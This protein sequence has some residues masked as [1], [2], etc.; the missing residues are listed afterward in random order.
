MNRKEAIHVLRTIKE[1]YPKY[2]ICKRK[3]SM[4][5]QELLPMDYTLVLRRLAKHVATHPYPP[6]ISEIAVYSRKRDNQ[7]EKL[8]KWREQAQDVPLE[9]R[10]TFH[11]QML[12]LIRGQSDEHD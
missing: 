4:L 3:A 1:V 9:L 5:I 7:V 12:E 11:K 8:A 10:E 6:T 2:D